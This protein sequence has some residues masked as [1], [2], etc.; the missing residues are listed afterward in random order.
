MTYDELVM[1]A[2]QL[3]E[4]EQFSK[5]PREEWTLEQWIDFLKE[6]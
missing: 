4:T 5:G 6:D 2:K 3:M 1:W